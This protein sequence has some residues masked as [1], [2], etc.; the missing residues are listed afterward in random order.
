MAAKNHSSWVPLTF[1]LTQTQ[2]AKIES[3]RTALN[4][5][6]ASEVVRLAI[7]RYDFASY[8]ARR[9]PQ[10]QISV[11]LAPELRE[12]LRRLARRKNVS[13]GE[14]LRE[15]LEHLAAPKSPGKSP[16]VKVRR[17]K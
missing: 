15:A 1:D 13:I 3:A 11:R 6:S 8:E 14:L 10:R 2:L 9:P 5:P 7:A 17:R 4:L 16:L 12:K